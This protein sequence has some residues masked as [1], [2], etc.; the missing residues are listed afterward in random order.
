M[1][2]AAQELGFDVIVTEMNQNLTQVSM[3]VN[4]CDVMVGVHGAGLTNMVFLPENGVLIQVVPWGNIDGIA[5]TCYGEPPNGMG[6]KYLEYKISVEESSLIEQY[7][8]NH[9]VLMNPHSIGRNGWLV[10]KS[11][12]MDKQNVT[13]NLVRFKEILSKSLELLRW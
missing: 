7:P 3:V 12:Y 11:I 6:L 2:S 1:V 10:L 8:L 4:S 13:L 5:K 9:Q